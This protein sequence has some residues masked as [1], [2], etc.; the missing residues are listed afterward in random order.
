MYY[1]P[2][3]LVALLTC[4]CGTPS[5]APTESASTAATADHD[6]HDA[7]CSC[8]EGK[9]GGTMWCEA[10]AKGYIKGQSTTDKAA[11]EKAVEGS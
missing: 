7:A 4:G 5:Q 11:V 2:L 6:G 1:R 3:F 9:A 8:K 10:C